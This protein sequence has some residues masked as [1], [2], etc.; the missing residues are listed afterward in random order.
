MIS[1]IE[2]KESSAVIPLLAR[3]PSQAIF[4]ANLQLSKNSKLRRTKP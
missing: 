2:I 4:L 1:K 3:S